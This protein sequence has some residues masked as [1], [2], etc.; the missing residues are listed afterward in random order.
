MVGRDGFEPSTLRFPDCVA[1]SLALGL[2][3]MGC[4]LA[5][6]NG[7]ILTDLS[8]GVSR[9]KGSGC[10]PT[11]KHIVYMICREPVCSSTTTPAGRPVKLALRYG[12]S[13]SEAIRRAVVRHRDA[14]LGVPAH[15]RKQRMKK[16]GELFELFEG[17]DAEEEIRQ[18]KTQDEGF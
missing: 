15:S 13:V 11:Y 17:H 12:C 4:I 16:L 8:W 5:G 3:R 6:C 9:T 7:G 2:G 10:I 1:P 18:L 14:M